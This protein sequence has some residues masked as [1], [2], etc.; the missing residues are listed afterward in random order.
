MKIQN[1]SLIACSKLKCL[2]AFTL[3]AI[4]LSIPANASEAAAG[5]PDKSFTVIDSIHYRDKGDMSAYNMKDYTIFYDSRIWP[6]GEVKKKAL[7][8]PPSDEHIASLV[9]NITT[10]KSPVIYDIERW[11]L[12]IRHAVKTVASDD[13]ATASNKT[14]NASMNKMIHIISESKKVNPNVKYGYYSCVPLRDYWVTVGNN[15]EKMK[16][17]QQAND[18][19]KP[20]VESVD[21]LCPSLYAFYNNRDGWVK[22]ARANIAEAKRLANGKPVYVYLWPKYHNSNKK[23]GKKFIEGDFWKL[24]L[25][26][27][28]NSGVDGIIIWDSALVVNNPKDKVW[29]PKREWWKE[30]VSFLARLKK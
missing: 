21:V 4:T 9:K 18:Y 16:E 24:Q 12:D 14:V 13:I 5:K 26:T 7:E 25:E 23:D 19:L 3:T 30:T 28:Y 20:L 2:V 15:P 17:W 29:D 8:M 10:A 27:V 6:S 11:P 1:S 22:Y